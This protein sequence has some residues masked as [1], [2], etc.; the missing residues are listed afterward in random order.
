MTVIPHPPKS[1]FVSNS[2]APNKGLELKKEYIGKMISTWCPKSEI[3]LDKLVTTSA[4][5]PTFAIGAISTAML[6]MCNGGAFSVD[7]LV[8]KW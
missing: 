6:M 2:L 8:G 1:K 5:P 7:P 3:A 4:K